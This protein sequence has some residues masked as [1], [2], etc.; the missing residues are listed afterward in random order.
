MHAAER[1]VRDW[2]DKGGWEEIAAELLYSTGA[3]RPVARQTTF[4][5]Y[6]TKE[7]GLAMTFIAEVPLANRDFDKPIIKVNDVDYIDQSDHIVRVDRESGVTEHEYGLELMGIPMPPEDARNIEAPVLKIQFTVPVSIRMA[8][9]FVSDFRSHAYYVA[10]NS[11]GQS[12]ISF[13]VFR[14][15]DE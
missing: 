11:I 8:H 7:Q 14:P 1:T 9:R 13:V 15:V 4:L 5:R 10:S 6:P 2:A 3:G 12:Q